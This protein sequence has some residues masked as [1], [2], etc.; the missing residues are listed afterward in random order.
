[1]SIVLI[2][3]YK[4][5]MSMRHSDAAG[6]RD[7]PLGLEDLLQRTRDALRLDEEAA[8]IGIVH[9]P[10]PTVM[11]F[12]DEL[13]VPWIKRVLIQEA[14]EVLVLIDHVVRVL[15]FD[16]LAEEAGHSVDDLG[17]CLGCGL[18]DVDQI[19]IHS[20]VLTLR[21]YEGIEQMECKLAPN[22]DKNSLPSSPQNKKPRNIAGQGRTTM[23]R[24][25]V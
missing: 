13:C 5:D 11:F 19:R 14:D 17:H 24:I 20:R 12:R 1:M 15:T 22:V 18:A 7:D 8:D 16:D 4:V 2:P 9:V 21:I 10:Y 23:Y 3:R 25:E 6:I